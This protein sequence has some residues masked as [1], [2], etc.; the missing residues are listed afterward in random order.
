MG[1]EVIATVPSMLESEAGETVAVSPGAAV[2]GIDIRLRSKAPS[3]SVSGQIVDAQ[4]RPARSARL[5]YGEIGGALFG[6]QAIATGLDRAAIR[7][8]G[9]VLPDRTVV[10]SSGEVADGVELFVGPRQP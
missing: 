6:T 7:R 8:S 1:V 3:Y 10:V 9:V 5:V 4:G 2:E